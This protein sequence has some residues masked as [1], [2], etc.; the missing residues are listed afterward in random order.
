MTAHPCR[1]IEPSYQRA[2]CPC[3]LTRWENSRQ[4]T[5]L[6]AL[7]AAGG[8]TIGEL[9]ELSSVTRSTVYRAR[10]RAS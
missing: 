2:A 4:E 1:A 3:R 10:T 8:H 5:H 7:H 9:E 6:V